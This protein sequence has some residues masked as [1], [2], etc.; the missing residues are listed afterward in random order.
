MAQREVFF[1]VRINTKERVGEGVYL[2]PKTQ[3]LQKVL[4]RIKIFGTEKVNRELHS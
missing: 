3:P 1:M 2:T 4:V